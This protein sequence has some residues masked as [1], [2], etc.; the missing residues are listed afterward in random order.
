MLIVTP[1]MIQNTII[2]AKADTN[3][4]ITEHSI[5]V[6]TDSPAVNLNASL[7]DQKL[8]DTNENRLTINGKMASKIVVSAPEFGKSLFNSATA[9]LN[10]AQTMGFD[11][12]M[13]GKGNS[14][15]VSNGKVVKSGTYYQTVT[16]ALNGNKS[17]VNKLLANY[18]T[19]VN[20]QGN[21]KIFV[22]S[23]TQTITIVRKI[24]VA[25]K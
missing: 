18:S 19:L 11:P 14:Q 25:T 9:A 22:N 13:T 8:N 10:Y 24:T 3:Q 15:A 1:V 20:G 23:K 12:S 6:S 4:L 21:Q 7:I 5:N 17:D 16:Y 2:S